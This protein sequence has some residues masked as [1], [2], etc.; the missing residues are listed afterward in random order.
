MNECLLN[1]DFKTIF[2]IKA[3]NILIT[4][5]VK[6]IYCCDTFLGLTWGITQYCYTNSCIIANAVICLHQIVLKIDNLGLNK[7]SL[8][9]N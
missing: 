2:H 6:G 5:K 9:D 7:V 3:D 1:Q 8:Y 4:G